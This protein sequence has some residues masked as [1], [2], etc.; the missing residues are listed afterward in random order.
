MH[1]SPCHDAWRCIWNNS[2]CTVCSVSVLL[3]FR[4]CGGV[5]AKALSVGTSNVSC[6][7]RSLSVGRM[8]TYRG[9]GLQNS[10]SNVLHQVAAVCQDVKSGSDTMPMS[11]L[12]LACLCC[13]PQEGGSSWLPLQKVEHAGAAAWHWLHRRRNCSVAK[14]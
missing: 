4:R 14:R 10:S 8:P 12:L 11:V 6:T 9:W 13:Q 3:V 7:L 2:Y 5:L 1:A